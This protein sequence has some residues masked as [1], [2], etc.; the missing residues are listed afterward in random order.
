MITSEYVC[1][2]GHK[3]NTTQKLSNTIPYQLCKQM[4]SF[5]LCWCKGFFPFFQLQRWRDARLLIN[6]EQCA[7]TTFN[8]ATFFVSQIE[9]KSHSH[10]RLQRAKSTTICHRSELHWDFSIE[11]K[12]KMQEICFSAAMENSKTFSSE[13]HMGESDFA[14]RKFF[15]SR[16]PIKAKW[17]GFSVLFSF[18]RVFLFMF[19]S[20]FMLWR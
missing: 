15:F 1:A 6:S 20:L 4:F 19:L 17:E 12:T 9:K 3:T 14:R 11:T 18:P 7:G 5:L 2:R 10:V 8:E 16:Q 13:C